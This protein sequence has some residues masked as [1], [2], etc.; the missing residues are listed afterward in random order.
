MP[1]E[2]HLEEFFRITGRYDAHGCVTWGALRDFYEA[3]KLD[4]P[5]Q[6]D[7]N[8][9][10]DQE[11]KEPP[12]NRVYVGMVYR[13]AERNDTP[14]RLDRLE[15]WIA[16]ARKTGVVDFERLRDAVCAELHA[17]VVTKVKEP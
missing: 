1:Q 13:E 5:P 16:D 7:Q 4:H 9:V 14:C 2:T 10:K 11:R 6:R 15:E 12:V 8:R 17:R 3:Y